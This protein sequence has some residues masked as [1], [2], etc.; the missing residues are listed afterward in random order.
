MKAKHIAL[1]LIPINI[2]LF[3][4]V[5]NSVNDYMEFETSAKIRISENIQK[6]KDL[7]QVQIGHKKAKG[8]YARDFNSLMLFLESGQIPTI[9]AIGEIPDEMTEEEALKLGLISRDTIYLNAKD[10]IFDE[11]YLRSRNKSFPL[12]IEKLH[13]IP[14]SEIEY[15]INAGTIEKGKVLVQV[16][17]ISATYENIL[18]GLNAKNKSYELS[19]LLKVGSMYEASLNGN[20]GE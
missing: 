2:I 9:K 8:Y 1:L 18:K 5:Y 12:D 19:N 11:I 10:N 16:F 20:W 7:R 17:E 4:C 3:G 15:N 6:L 14:Q 13:Q